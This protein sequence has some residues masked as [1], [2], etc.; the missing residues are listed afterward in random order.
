M[1]PQGRAEAETNLDAYLEATLRI[2]ERICN[3]PVAYQQF[4]TLTDHANARY[5]ESVD[6]PGISLP[7]TPQ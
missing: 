1:S 7:T 3:D 5:D 6:P 4:R 2:F